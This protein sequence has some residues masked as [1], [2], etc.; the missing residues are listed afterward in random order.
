[1]KRIYLLWITCFFQTAFGQTP[2]TELY[3]LVRK[4]VTDSTGY[5]NIGDWAVGNPK[6]YPV[7]W[8]ADKIEM[9]ND[10]SIN[11]YRSGTAS[12]VVKSRNSS[13]PAIPIVWNVMLK[14]PRMGYGSFSM[15]STP[16]PT[17]GPRPT[18][19]SLFG[20]K[21]YTAKLLKKCDSK[22]FAGYYYYQLKL[23]KKDVV[24]LKL[25]WLSGTNGAYRLDVFDSYSQYQAKLNCPQ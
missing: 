12:V 19:D 25:S 5:E 17:L 16:S 20:N 8:K 21:P 11:F 9:S 10:T 22:D 13:Q 2:S 14:G 1:M 15:L 4:L 3:D 18:I 24:F 6:K 23:P 7:K